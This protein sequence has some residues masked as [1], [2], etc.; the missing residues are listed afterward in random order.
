M[1]APPP[2]WETRLHELADGVFAYVQAGGGFC[3]S[4]AGFVD[5]D[6]GSAVAIDALFSPKMT[7]GFQEAVRGVS[8]VPVGRLINTHHHVDH[9]LGNGLFAGAAVIAHR[10]ARELMIRAG[11]HRDRMVGMAPWFDAE[12]PA[13]IPLRPPDTVF[14]RSLELYAGG[15]RLVLFHVG[16]A[17]TAGDVLVHLPEERILFA[18]DV[19]FFYVTPLAFEGSIAGWTR[20]LRAV[21]EMGDVET[22]VP[23]HGPVGGVARVRELLAYFEV[24]TGEARARFDAGLDE[25]AAARELP[26]GAFASWCE[27]ER[28]VPNVYRLYAQFRGDPEGPIDVVRAFAGMAEFASRTP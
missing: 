15:R 4:N 10:R 27:A 25:D 9:T 5:D 23:G 17:H 18:G 24:I 13:E 22:I 14:E 6:A 28:I 12:L 20:A 21:E 26:L 1:N 8:S 2:A 19:C 16:T 11:F 7:L 3:V